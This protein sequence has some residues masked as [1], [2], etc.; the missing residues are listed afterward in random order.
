M[1]LILFGIVESMAS[2]GKSR[3]TIMIY[4]LSIVCTEL[5]CCV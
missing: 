3:I 2:M 5:R 4:I 1:T